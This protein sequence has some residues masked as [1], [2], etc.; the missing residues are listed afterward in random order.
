MPT[1]GE[2]GLDG[3]PDHQ[4][5]W[6]EQL[7]IFE[8][9]LGFCEKAGGRT[10]SLHSRRAVSEVMAALT[11]GEF[12][13]LWELMCD[14]P[15]FPPSW[16]EWQAL[17]IRRRMEEERRGQKVVFVDVRVRDF[18]TFCRDKG[19]PLGWGALTKFTEQAA[20]GGR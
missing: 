16:Q 10:M 13:E 12:L 2:I 1:L 15:D 5:S 4:S 3:S 17:W 18:P 7:A 8:Q 20:A 6:K 11:E 9:V 19:F 14:V